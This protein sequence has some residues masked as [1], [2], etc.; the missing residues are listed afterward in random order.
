[1]ELEAQMEMTFNVIQP[2][3]AEPCSWDKFKEWAEDNGIS[4]LTGDWEPWWLC[5]NN[6]FL[7]GLNVVDG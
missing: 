2:D 4:P 5:W 6:G 3:D 7:V 1:L